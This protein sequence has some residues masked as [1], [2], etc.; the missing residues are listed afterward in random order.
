MATIGSVTLPEYKID[1]LCRATEAKREQ[2]QQR[3]RPLECFTSSES[4][5]HCVAIRQ[6]RRIGAAPAF[7]V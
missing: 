2:A 4:Y 1:S 7:S 3:L 5:Y 6:A